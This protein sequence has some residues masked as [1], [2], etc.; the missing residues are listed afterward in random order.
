VKPVSDG[1]WMIYGAN[2]YTGSLCAREAV[3]RGKR[4]ILAGR[5]EAAVRALAA[6]CD[7]EARVFSLDDP[8]AVARQLEDITAVLHCAGP[9]SATHR[10]MIEACRRS[11]THYLDITGEVGVFEHVHGN[12]ARWR[13]AGIVALPGVGFDV[14]P[15]DCVAAMLHRELPQATHLRLAFQALGGGMS[16]GT[17]KT[18]L[19]GLHAGA[20]FRRDGKL[21]R[22]PLAARTTTIP[23]AGQPRAAVMIS[24]GDIATAYYSTGIP[25]IEV[26]MVLP[27]EQ[28]RRLRWVRRLVWALRLPGVRRGLQRLVTARVRGPT[29]ARRAAGESLVYGEA[30]AADG[31][32]RSMTLRTP[33]GYTHTVH[34]ALAAV[35]RL[36][37]D[38]VA[39]GAH[40]PSTAFGPEFVLSL[41]DVRQIEAP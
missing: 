10:P 37:A 38:Q 23:F 26:Y 3:L 21:A 41:P 32:G 6:G 33:E 31:A 24:W 34:A 25:N 1:R 20:L 7:L 29:D 17:A 40:T 15:T 2:G 9:F 8:Q 5:N 14:V 16:A 39:P 35:E 13:D 36:L 22:E 30:T 12:A 19:E 27:A 4:P 11:G 28:L 18:M